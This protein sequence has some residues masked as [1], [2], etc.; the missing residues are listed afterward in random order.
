[1]LSIKFQEGD[2]IGLMRKSNGALHYYINGIDQGVAATRT[3]QQVWGVIDLYGMAVKVSIVDRENATYPTFSGDN[4]FMN[5]RTN[6]LI[7]RMQ[8]FE[9]EHVEGVESK[10]LWLYTLGLNG[11]LLTPPP[12]MK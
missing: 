10:A 1:M 8:T 6:N 12:P 4:T 9:T 5:N 3:P 7:R 2:H 11:V